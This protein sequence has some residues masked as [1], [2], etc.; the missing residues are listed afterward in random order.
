VAK[1]AE[2]HDGFT[3]TVEMVRTRFAESVPVRERAYLQILSPLERKSII[4]LGACD[5]V[6]GRSPDCDIRFVVENVSRKHA[7]IFLTTKSS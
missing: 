4:E 6:I 1:S 2:E 5:I 7:R 3:T